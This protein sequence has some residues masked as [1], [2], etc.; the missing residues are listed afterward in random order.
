MNQSEIITCDVTNLVNAFHKS[1]KANPSK[2]EN[3]RF[4]LHQLSEIQ[5]AQD[6]LHSRTWNISL[7]KPFV[8]NERGHKRRVEGNTP[9]DRMIIHSWVDN[10]LIP[11]IEPY[12]SRDNYSSRKGMGTSDARSRF[13]Y[14]IH[15]AY[16]KYGHNRFYILFVDFSKYY[17]NIRHD[18]LKELIF[19]YVHDDEFNRYMVDNIL[20]SF[21]VDV[22]WMND[23]EYESCLDKCYNS[24]LHLND[25]CS[26]DL[27]MNKSLKMGNPAS[28]I[29][30]ILFPIKIDNYAK[31]KRGCASSGRYVDDSSYISDN[32]DYLYSILSG[33][34]DIATEYGI[35]INEK[36]TH[37][38]RADKPFTF[39]NRIYQMTESGHLK[40]KLSNPTL[41]RESRKL[42]KFKTMLD[43][44]NIS[45]IKIKNQFDSWMGSNAKYISKSQRILIKELYFD[46]FEK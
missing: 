35:F 3:K 39:L 4:K 2:A 11:S 22:S 28:Q 34:G 1:V 20:N 26:G 36:K 19:Q 33:I 32:I 15:S 43:N 27:F 31:I 44:G 12:L 37:I 23:D 6:E 24:L 8:I 38:C 41:H 9:Y 14:F 29:F 46:L 25:K 5:R 18:R 13:E 16:R 40:V 45:K 17:D 21:A 42:R 10:I 7:K 30:S